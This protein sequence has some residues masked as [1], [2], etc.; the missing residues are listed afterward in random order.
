MGQAWVRQ[1]AILWMFGIFFA[2]SQL[3]LLQY[4]DHISLVTCPIGSN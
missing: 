1:S 2:V 4:S 3:L